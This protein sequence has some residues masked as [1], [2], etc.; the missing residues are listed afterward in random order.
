MCSSNISVCAWQMYYEPTFSCDTEMRVG[1][2]GDGGKWVCDPH[3][4]AD[5]CLVYS[6]G[7]NGQ[8]DFEEGV[9]D[10][11]S[12]RCEI[13]TIDMNHWEKYGTKPPPYVSYHV[14][15]V[16]NL[17]SQ[18]TPVRNIV[19]DLH[20]TGRIIDIFKIDCEGCEWESIGEWF[21]EGVFIRQILVELHGPQDKRKAI[22]F[23]NYLFSL[24]YVVFH[25]EANIQY[26]SG[27]NLCIEYAFVRL[28][29]GEEQV[30]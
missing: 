23:F 15:T 13:H 11:I 27:E 10:R 19:R 17:A 5:S 16:G 24:G 26:S 29:A 1:M 8:F 4:F 25:K 3:K 7:S 20:H 30:A 12:S 6:I 14:Y 28:Q 2:V 18:H 21:G 9:H 22:G